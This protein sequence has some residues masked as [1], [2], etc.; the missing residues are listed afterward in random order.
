MFQLRITDDLAL[1]NATRNK[2][3]CDAALRLHR[4]NGGTATVVETETGQR[5]RPSTAIPAITVSSG[6]RFECERNKDRRQLRQYRV[7]RGPVLESPDAT[8]YKLGTC[9][10]TPPPAP[11][12][13]AGILRGRNGRQSPSARASGRAGM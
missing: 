8:V 12:F 10:Y 2:R 13:P 6:V 3:D 11:R 5:P 1:Q 4:D 7:Q 9:Q